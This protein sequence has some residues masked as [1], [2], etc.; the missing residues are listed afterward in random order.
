MRELYPRLFEPRPAVLSI[1][2]ALRVD[3]EQARLFAPEPEPE[4]GGPAEHIAAP[5]RD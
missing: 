2:S 1:N 3:A 4:V 5:L